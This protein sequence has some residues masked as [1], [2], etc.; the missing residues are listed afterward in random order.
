[1]SRLLLQNYFDSPHAVQFFFIFSTHHLQK[2]FSSTPRFT[3]SRL[4]LQNCFDS[5]HAVQF[6]FIFSIHHPQ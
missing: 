5:P 4:L 6:F 3:M 2:T 1:M